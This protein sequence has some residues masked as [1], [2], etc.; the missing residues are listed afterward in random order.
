MLVPYSK[1]VGKCPSR[2]ELC[3]VF[4][5][6]HLLCCVPS[7]QQPL[8]DALVA[9]CVVLLSNCD[10]LRLGAHLCSWRGSQKNIHLL[11]NMRSQLWCLQ[12]VHVRQIS[13]QPKE[14]LKS[15]DIL[16]FVWLRG[17]T[18]CFQALIKAHV[19]EHKDGEAKQYKCSIKYCLGA[20]IQM[21]M[22]TH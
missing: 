22:V 11:A 19:F 5:A 1:G 16:A 13:L 12:L 4:I 8:L 10:G 14:S 6:V 21:Y 2:L 18:D 7:S 15:G 9:S 20:E 17:W 3:S